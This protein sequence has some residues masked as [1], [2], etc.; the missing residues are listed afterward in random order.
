MLR[1]LCVRSVQPVSAGVDPASSSTE[2]VAC[3]GSRAHP[4]TAENPFIRRR[5][6]RRAAGHTWKSH[7]RGVTYLVDVRD[8]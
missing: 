1:G 7:S 5:S 3:A 6:Y 8:G 4:P 2:Q